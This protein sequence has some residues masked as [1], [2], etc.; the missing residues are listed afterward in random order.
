MA[1]APSVLFFIS[2]ISVRELSCYT[3]GPV[4]GVWTER[5]DRF[6]DEGFRL[7]NYCPESQCTPTRSA[8][9]TGRHAIR[10]GTHSVPLGSVEPWGLVAWERT[11]ADVLSEAGMRV[12]P[13]GSG[14]SGKVLGGG[15]PTMGFRSGTARRGPMTSRCGRMTLGMTRLVTRSLGWLRSLAGSR[16]RLSWTS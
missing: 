1:G 2:T 6:A 15:R 11:I 9:M 13:T 8:L 5:I 4:R 10:S 3:G 14:M 7:T 12:R 16:S